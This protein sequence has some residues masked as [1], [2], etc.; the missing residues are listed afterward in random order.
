MKS[1]RNHKLLSRLT[2]HVGTFW[3]CSIGLPESCL[4]ALSGGM[5]STLL[6]EVCANLGRVH[7]FN[8]RAIHVDHGTQQKQAMIESHLHEQCSRLGVELV[9]VRTVLSQLAGNFEAT[10]RDIRLK[11][12]HE[13]LLGSEVVAFGH[14]IDDSFEWSLMQKLRS[15][16]LISTLGIPVI[17]KKKV[18]PFMCLTRAQIESIHSKLGLW[19]FEDESNVNERFSRN[20]LRRVI[21][22]EFANRYPNYL[23]HY[24]RTSNELAKKLGVC[25]FKSEEV[26]IKKSKGIRAIYCRDIST[27]QE[28]VSKQFKELSN[29]S[30]S[31]ERG[32]IAKLC[33]AFAA[34]KKGPH[35]L[36]GNVKAWGLNGLVLLTDD[37]GAK[38]LHNLWNIGSHIPKP[39]L[40][41]KSSPAPMI[42]VWNPPKNIKKM[43]FKTHPLVGFGPKS[44]AVLLP[45]GKWSRFVTQ[46]SSKKIKLHWQA[47]NF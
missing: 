17:N 10:A 29:V 38:H 8:V 12:I 25:V 23:K 30:R 6:L 32:E 13:N 3:D 44:D 16:Q 22:D 39:C 5:D 42:V 7:G 36:P 15:S 18:R 20:H 21:K 31:S 24:V 35:Q 46:N 1:S 27:Q 47:L 11:L 37:F 2:H 34:G 45:W 14:H 9:I 26:I 40:I 43:G 28:V 19:S 33:K 4:V 41:Q